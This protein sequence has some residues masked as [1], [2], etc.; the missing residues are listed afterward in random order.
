ML[1]VAVSVNGPL[2]A[3]TDEGEILLSVGGGL[4][5][6]VTELLVPPSITELTTVT[7]STVANFKADANTV[8]ERVPS[9]FFV[10]T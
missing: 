10:V 6:R 7:G 3:A 2:P 4:T 1:P 8:A 5:V 9:E